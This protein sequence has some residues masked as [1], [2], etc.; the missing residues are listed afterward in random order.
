M[1][2]FLLT[3]LGAIIF[4][5]IST[6]QTTSDI[7]DISNTHNLGTARYNGLSGAFGALGGDL[8]AVAENPAGGAVFTN[9][10]G[11][12]TLSQGSSDFNSN[13]FNTNTPTNE[14]NFNFNQIGGILILKNDD[15]SSSISKISLGLLFNKD[16]DYRREYELNGNSSTG[17]IGGYFVGQANGFTVDT[18]SVRDGEDFE[19]AYIDIGESNG[20]GVRG[21]QAFLA[22]EAFIITEDESDDRLYSSEVSG[23][24]NSQ[25]INTITSGRS[26]KISINLAFEI[27]K[28][29]Y[30]GG[31]LN[32]HNYDLRKRSLISEINNET[33]DDVSELFF[34]T[35]SR[36]FGNGFSLSLGAIA[37][38]SK[39][40]RVGL[41]Y[42][43][44]TWS[45]LQN[46]LDQNLTSFLNINNNEIREIDPRLVFLYPE[47]D[48]RTPGE[49]AASFAYV[50]GKNGLFSAQYSRKDF[51][52]IE[53]GDNA[54][55]FDILNRRIKNT[56]QAVNTIKV[57]G[58]YRYK[59]WRLRGGINYATSPYKNDQIAGDTQGFSLGTGYDWGKWKL[60]IAYNRIETDINEVP[61]ENDAYNN[62]AQINGKNDAISV[63]LGVNF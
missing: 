42:Q 59:K 31:N 30:L 24:G 1:K 58:E 5:A 25:K 33:T 3:L 40:L 43:T 4:S 17:N 51:S 45:T 41:S 19:S 53:Y 16:N 38:V 47:Y 12:A 36:T 22:R 18:I 63:T 15:D 23:I 55:D 20:F 56:F 39:Q 10:Y 29:I 13:Y 11:S 8:T 21:Q 35:R 61:F 54:F 37:K 28:K 6:G 44:P 14:A 57:G 26:S 2:K 48:L 27:D 52:N 7:F 49:I 34:E 9:S 50:F 62:S 46:E 60:D 32:F